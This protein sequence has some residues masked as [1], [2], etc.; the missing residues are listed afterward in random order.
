MQADEADYVSLKCVSD[1]DT[2]QYVCYQVEL[3]ASHAGVVE[4]TGNYRLGLYSSV[5]HV[6]NAESVSVDARGYCM[7]YFCFDEINK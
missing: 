7:S 1:E 4:I 3:N 6:E 2:E 5:L